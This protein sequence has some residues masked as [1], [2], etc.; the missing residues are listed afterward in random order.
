MAQ[1]VPPAWLQSLIDGA[2]RAEQG[3]RAAFDFLGLTQATHGQPAWPFNWRL[4]DEALLMDAGYAR[5][6][7]GALGATSLVLLLVAVAMCSRRARWPALLL[8]VLLVAL[9]PLPSTAPLRQEA[10]PTSFHASPTGFSAQSIVN[11]RRTYELHCVS[12][13][14]A[15]AEGDGPK[16]ASLRKWPPT[17]TGALL[18]QRME[19]ELFW[20]IRHGMRDHAGE[21]TMPGFA[22]YL[23][24]TQTWEVIDF[25]KA[26]AAGVSAVATGAWTW[27]IPAPGAVVR[28]R[29]GKPVPTASLKGQN[30]RIAFPSP[31]LRQLPPDPR[32]TTLAV[33]DGSFA[34][35]DCIVAPAVVGEAFAIVSGIPVAGLPGTQFL[36]DRGGWLRARVLPGSNDWSARDY[37]CGPLAGDAGAKGEGLGGLIARIDANPVSLLLGR[38]SHA[39]WIN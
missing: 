2:H 31:G 22:A 39:G 29:D 30:V 24:D 27:P 28:C 9:A 23:D 10:Y 32:L 7:A 12:C 17:L 37:M 34:G 5:D 21:Q 20:R 15:K 4:A 11:G 13:H 33:A 26:N 8:A 18:W 6:V 16:A 3:L 1:S 14:G 36:V 25:L 35:A 19:G 38:A